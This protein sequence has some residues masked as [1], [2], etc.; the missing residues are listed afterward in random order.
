ME[1]EGKE[2]MVWMRVLT[3]GEIEGWEAEGGK[4]GCGSCLD[5]KELKVEVEGRRKVSV[6]T[7][8]AE[9]NIPYIREGMINM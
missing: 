2:D 8:V 4:K 3:G 6:I 7:Y 1:G 5:G 9:C